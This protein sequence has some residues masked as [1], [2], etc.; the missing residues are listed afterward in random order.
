MTLQRPAR[1]ASRPAGRSVVRRLKG[2]TTKTVARKLVAKKIAVKKAAPRKIT[3]KKI[4]AKKSTRAKVLVVDKAT[5]VVDEH[6]EIARRIFA[7]AE[8]ISKMRLAQQQARIKRADEKR[9]NAALGIVPSAKDKANVRALA[10]TKPR[11]ARAP[12]SRIK[13]SAV[14]RI[15]DPPP[16]TG[17]VLI[18][19]VTGSIE[20]ELTQIETIIG[21]HRVD[22]HRRTEAER[23]ARTLASLARTLSELK[24]LGPQ[25]GEGKVKPADDDDA[26]PRDLDEFRRELSRRLDQMVGRRAQISDGDDE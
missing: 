2:G 8:M 22:P 3:A 17:A 9:A 13:R 7:R 5:L 18:D 12:S 1:P 15:G 10:H 11:H 14:E 21:A 25:S 6:D 16:A 4:P 23:R 26:V 19:R 24:R 20:R